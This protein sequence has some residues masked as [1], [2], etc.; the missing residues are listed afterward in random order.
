[1][2]WICIIGVVW[3]ACSPAQAQLRAADGIAALEA[4]DAATARDIWQQLA[5]RGDVL[6]QYNLGVLTLRSGSDAARWFALAAEQGHLPA[7]TAL[8]GLLA[9]AQDWAGAARWYEA[10][11]QQGDAPSA[12]ALGLLLDRGLWG[13]RADAPR[14]F[15]QAATAGHVPAQFALGTVLAEQG[16]AEAATWFAR[17]AEAGHVEAQFNHAR[18]LMADDPVA[19]RRWYAKAGAA[20]FGAA[21]YNLAL[22]QARGQGGPARFEIGLAWAKVAQHQGFGQAAALVDALSD[23]MLPEAVARA[24]AVAQ[25]CL[26]QPDTCPDQGLD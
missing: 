19:A 9:D 4:G 1:M 3:L 17:A 12:H 24:D 23:V 25:S 10:A 8:A 2:R 20:G 7:Q 11:A 22:M 6:A 21:S 26:Q 13:A 18:G 5:E 16:A 14:W 15:R